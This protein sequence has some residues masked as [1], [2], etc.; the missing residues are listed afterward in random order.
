MKTKSLLVMVLAAMGLVAVPSSKAAFALAEDVKPEA[1][2]I[3][4]DSYFAQGW[5]GTVGSIRT[6][7][8]GVYVVDSAGFGY[9]GYINRT[10]DFKDFEISVD[11]SEILPNSALGII[12]GAPLT[13]S[14]EQGMVLNF[15]VVKSSATANLYLVTCSTTVN[16]HNISIP[17]F[18]NGTWAED[19]N[20]TGVQFTDTD[21]IID[22]SLKYIDDT[23][24]KI[25]V[26]DL[27]FTLATSD[28]YSRF[29]GN[30]NY[31]CNIGIFN[32]DGTKQYFKINSIGDASDDVYFAETGSFGLVKQT[33]ADLKGYDLGDSEQLIQ[34]QEKFESMPYDELY[35]WDKNYFKTD[36]D[37][38]KDAIQ[39]AI[40]SAGN[41]VV[42]NLF[43]TAVVNLET[44]VLDLSNIENINAAIV[45]RDTAEAKKTDIVIENLNNEE[46]TRYNALDAR[47]Q[48]AKES[49]VTAARSA[50]ENAVVAYETAVENVTST[51]AILDAQTARK[52]IPNAYYEFLS[53]DEQTALDAR[54]AAADNKLSENTT[55]DHANWTQGRNA[56]VSENEDGSYGL[57]S[58]GDPFD[59]PEN[60]NG[61]FN[62]EKL[63]ALDFETTINFESIPQKIGSWVTF[64]LM[65]KP[66]MWINAEDDS[67]QNNKGIFFLINRVSPQRLSVQAFLCSLTSN[68]FYDS[69]LTQIIEIPYGEEIKVRFYT[70]NV[71]IAGV[72]EEYFRMS[73]NDISYD[74]EMITARKIKTVLGTECVGHFIMA[75]SGF[76][77]SDPA[78]VTIKNINEKSPSGDSIVADVDLTPTSTD[79]SKTFTKGSESAIV[80]FNL[81]TKGQDL[82]AVKV[83]GSAIASSNYT[84]DSSANKLTLTNAYLNTLTVGEHTVVAETSEGS[85]TWTLTVNE[86]TTNPGGSTSEPTEPT[87]P[88]ESNVGLIIGLSVAGGLVVIAGI[89]LLVVLLLKKRASKQK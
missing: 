57:V 80:T 55:I 8:R 71:E 49:I 13:Y 85:V 3:A 73:F 36:Y 14:S 67:V 35:N 46:L 68:R 32:N 45:L 79:T 28:V 4:S 42:L 61:I 22:L 88:N 15:D 65:E 38:T 53:E 33:L 40:V 2:V 21:G 30:Y 66:E 63:S 48:T 41:E 72:A 60:S 12:I 70:E 17:G 69:A 29:E 10:Y 87:T 23:S 27:S 81:D 16:G 64:G 74:Q 62:S 1:G 43:E 6:S 84:F 5:Q 11:I 51:Q 39:E 56:L 24:T 78:I 47:L 34:A 89:V 82:T 37:S 86:D 52:N 59:T 44:A 58:Y 20:Y 75:S 19:A 77:S 9:R 76:D 25:T 31:Y 83:D 26:N 50:L 7:D 54:I 18:N